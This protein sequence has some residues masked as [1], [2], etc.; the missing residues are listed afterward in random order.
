MRWFGV[1][2]CKEVIKYIIH[3]RWDS[4]SCKPSAQGQQATYALWTNIRWKLLLGLCANQLHEGE[5]HLQG[6]HSEMYWHPSPTNF[7]GDIK[8]SAPLGI[9]PMMCTA[10]QT[11]FPIPLHTVKLLF[12]CIYSFYQKPLE[13]PT[14]L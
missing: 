5:F 7:N 14:P 3:I 1:R 10:V 11:I 4:P 8:H 2:T 13:N 9:K 12:L 6:L